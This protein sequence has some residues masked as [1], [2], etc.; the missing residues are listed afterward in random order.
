[1]ASWWRHHVFLTILIIY[2][3]SWEQSKVQYLFLLH[4]AFLPETEHL[5]F[6]HK[7]SMSSLV[8][9]SIFLAG[10]WLVFEVR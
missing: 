4:Q 3:K 6:V 10:V 5:E 2:Y 7:L 1:M 8:F 9:V